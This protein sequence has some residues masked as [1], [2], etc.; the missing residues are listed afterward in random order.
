MRVRERQRTVQCSRCPI[1][2]RPSFARLRA[3]APSSF[4]RG[5]GRLEGQ[6]APTKWHGAHG[7]LW[8]RVVSRT[9]ERCGGRKRRRVYPSRVKRGSSLF[10]ADCCTFTR[11][12]LGYSDFLH[13]PPHVHTTKVGATSTGR[14]RTLHML[15]GGAKDHLCALAKFRSATCLGSPFWTAPGTSRRP[16]RQQGLRVSAA[17]EDRSQRGA[18]PLPFLNAPRLRRSGGGCRRVS[19]FRRCA[20]RGWSPLDR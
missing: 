7:M 16:D 5:G 17:V 14:I 1:Q 6:T 10:K 20:G 2:R 15:L 13:A 3:L 4:C 12:M 9:L 8:C 18:V 11:T 19:R